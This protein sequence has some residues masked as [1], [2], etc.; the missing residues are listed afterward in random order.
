VHVLKHLN[1]EDSC[2]KRVI[3]LG[4]LGFIGGAIV[5]KLKSREIEVLF[6][7]RAELDL[8][9]SSSAKILAGILRSDD[10]LVFVSAK[11]PCKDIGMLLVNI[12]MAS[13]VCE[14]LKVN[15]V[16]HVVYISSDAVYADSSESITESASA[17]PNSI[18]GV[19]HLAREVALKQEYSGPLAIVRPTLVYGLKDPHNGY[20]PNRFNRLAAEGKEI[21]LFGEGEER[22]DHVDVAD[23]AELVLRIILR[24][25]EGTINA[26]SGETV[27]FREL[28]EYITSFFSSQSHIK[29]SIR[30]GPMPHNGYRAF[31][32]SSISQAFPGFSFKSWKEGLSQ[33]NKQHQKQINK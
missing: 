16:S 27:S 24:K 5:D 31:D 33:M 25:S 18:H 17:Q 8:T 1:L 9:A 26:V 13:T 10:V 4:G 11:A 30:N 28:A 14:A 12:Q 21:T 2:P 32:S 3:V 19:M 22:R 15:P 20:G 6:L 29:G 23:I 7:G